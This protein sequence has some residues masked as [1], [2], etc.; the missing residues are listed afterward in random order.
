MACLVAAR[1]QALHRELGLGLLPPFAH[2]DRL[3]VRIRVGPGPLTPDL[4]QIEEGNL[5]DADKVGPA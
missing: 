1:A 4:C 5:L 2:A 3:T